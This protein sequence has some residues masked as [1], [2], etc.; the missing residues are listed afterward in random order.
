MTTEEVEA[1]RREKRE[2]EATRKQLESLYGAAKG[3]Q[4]NVT[5]YR[6]S[7]K[8]FMCGA[9][10]K[11]S[12]DIRRVCGHCLFPEPGTM[13]FTAAHREVGDAGASLLKAGKSCRAA[14]ADNINLLVIP[15]TSRCYRISPS[16]SSAPNHSAASSQK[17][18]GHPSERDAFAEAFTEA[19]PPPRRNP[20][21]SDYT[22]FISIPIGS[23]PGV[24]EELTALME[25]M[26]S[27]AASS[28]SSSSAI[29]PEIFNSVE[30]LHITLHLLRLHSKEEVQ[31]AKELLSSFKVVWEDEKKALSSRAEWA[32]AFGVDGP[33][34]TLFPRIRLGGVHVMPSRKQQ[35]QYHQ[36]KAD[37]SCSPPAHLPPCV[38]DPTSAGILFMGVADE[39]SAQVILRIREAV[40]SVFQHQFEDES[41]EEE[42]EQTP[43]LH[44]TLIN[45]KWRA[46]AAK[47]PFDA[48]ALLS[49]FSSATI[50]GGE[51][52]QAG[53]KFL[54]QEVRLN[55]LSASGTTPGGEYF[56][57]AAV[58]A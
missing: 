25:D 21:K 45:K 47:R 10:G 1:V 49:R 35:Q 36:R 6:P 54:L 43:I 27:V 34:S 32:D 20:N 18:S 15:R 33:F 2:D 9:C 42:E 12:S 16:Y 51:H 56:C 44:M 57:E 26:K 3:R 31:L 7:N 41:D 53:G 48:S 22:H 58:E 52:Q 13:S 28:S 5:F 37:A 55:R 19:V 29:T 46:T 39:L 40:R 8:A 38:G 17:K 11:T 4:G 30:R 23:L 24:R 50:E 14:K